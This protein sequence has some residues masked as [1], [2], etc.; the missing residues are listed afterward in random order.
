MSP[1]CVMWVLTFR[2]ECVFK[3]IVD[4]K[5]KIISLSHPALFPACMTS[6]EVIVIICMVIVYVLYFFF[7]IL[8]YV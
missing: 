5:M 6:M 4:L 2:K 3:E 1:K 8:K 7:T